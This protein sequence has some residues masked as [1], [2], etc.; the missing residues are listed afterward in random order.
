MPTA[1]YYNKMGK[2]LPGTTTI[3]G[4]F[5]ESEFLIKWAWEQGC[6]GLNYRRTRD[7]AADS[8]TVTHELVDAH[9]H[10]RK[11]EIDLY[12][13]DIVAKGRV[14]FAGFLKWKDEF[15]VD[16]VETEMQLVSEEFQ[17]GGTPD[18]IGRIDG[19]LCMIDWKTSKRVYPDHLLQLA[20][21]KI[22][23]DENRDEEIDGPFHLLRFDKESGGFEHHH[24]A[25][26]DLDEAREAFVHMRALYGLMQKVGK[27]VKS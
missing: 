12:P 22:L 1:P 3:I 14:G 5:K 15:H 27:Q 10:N 23:W 24:W 9:I 7:S 25:L 26:G 2:R 19:K 20:A 21:Y 16:Y 8:G 18:A 4:R 11:P 13:K 6:A 17:F